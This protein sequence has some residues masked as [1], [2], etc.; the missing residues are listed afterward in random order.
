[1]RSG[2]PPVNT[3]A[4]REAVKP[5]P[6]RCALDGVLQALLTASRFPYSSRPSA[7]AGVTERISGVA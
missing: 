1:M 7:L 6:P 4:K 3:T 5:E 2:H